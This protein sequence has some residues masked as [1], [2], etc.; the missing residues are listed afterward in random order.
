V[1]VAE[2]IA[3]REL[4]ELLTDYL[5]GAIPLADRARIDAHLAL[6]DGCTRAL[7]QLRRTIR[8]T[9]SIGIEDVPAPQ[10]EAM[11]A[12]FRDWRRSALPD[13]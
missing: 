3:C 2:D 12:A 8:V 9:G 7:D 1:S 11:R 13:A 5:E 10:R 4:M 6:C